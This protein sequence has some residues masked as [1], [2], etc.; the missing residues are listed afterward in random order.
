MMQK[1]TDALTNAA[2]YGID[3]AVWIISRD[4]QTVSVAASEGIATT[5][6]AYRVKTSSERDKRAEKKRYSVKR[7]AVIGE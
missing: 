5:W 7:W 3:R 1:E 6:I 4:N 2:E